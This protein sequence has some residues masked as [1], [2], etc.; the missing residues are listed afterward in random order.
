MRKASAISSALSGNN[1]GRMAW[2][3][4][5]PDMAGSSVSVNEK[6]HRTHVLSWLVLFDNKLTDSPKQALA[7]APGRKTQHLEDGQAFCVG[8]NVAF[9]NWYKETGVAYRVSATYSTESEQFT[10]PIDEPPIVRW[11]YERTTKII[12]TDINGNAILNKAGD[13]YENPF[14]IPDVIEAFTYTRNLPYNPRAMAKQFRNKI[15]SGAWL[16]YA[17]RT[18]LC[19]G[20]EISDRQSAMISETVKQYYW[21]V[22]AEVTIKEDE[23]KLT[24]L[25]QGYR[26]KIGGNLVDIFVPDEDGNPSEE[27]VQFPILLN[28]IG[29][30]QLEDPKVPIFT[31]WYVFGEEDFSGLG[32][33]TLEGF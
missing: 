26:E 25:E 18:A 14:E 23:W 5:I 10:N 1:W 20:I 16:D 17:A 3:D 31:D 27:R 22:T 28:N 30:A 11:I 15:N 32:I 8:T 4:T 9:A 6:G 13:K 33:D 19:S 24:A 7:F 12:E 2:V 29:R 21:T